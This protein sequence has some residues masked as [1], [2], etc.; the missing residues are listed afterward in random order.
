[1]EN[2]AVG[3]HVHSGWA[4]AVL[5]VGPAGAPEAADCRVVHLADPADPDSRR[6]YHAG[7][8]LPKGVAART[9]RQLVRSVEVFARRSL[10]DLFKA[11]RAG[12]HHLRAAGIVVGSTADPAT[13]P[14]DQGRADAEEGQLYRVVIQNAAQGYG[15]ALSVTVTVEKDLLRTASRK[16]GIPER[17]LEERVGAF[18]KRL[19]GPWRAEQKA[20]ALAAWMGLLRRR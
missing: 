10:L 13:I 5:L 11:Y 9:V 8:D 20:A 17:R 4:T 12:G 16:L 2:A 7:L 3:F 6:P 19:D 15:P 14:S 1:M 18:G